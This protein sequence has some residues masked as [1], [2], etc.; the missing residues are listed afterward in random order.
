VR[1]GWP[2]PAPA[3]RKGII[4]RDIKPGNILLAEDGT[5]KITDFGLARMAART[6]DDTSDKTRTGAI[7]GTPSYMAPEQAAGKTHDVGPSVDLYA[8]GAILYECLTGRPP[9]AGPTMLDTLMMVI[10][11][12]PVPPRQ[13]NAAIPRD[14]ET[15]CLK[16]L[17]KEVRNRY[18]SAAE[19]AD[20]LDRY[21]ADEPILA[22]PPG[23]V[24][25]INRWVRTHQGLPLAAGLILLL[26][27]GAFALGWLPAVK[28]LDDRV[29]LLWAVPLL[30]VI[31]PLSLLSPGRWSRVAVVPFL[32]AALF[33]SAIAARM[34]LAGGLVGVVLLSSPLALVVLLV[35]FYRSRGVRALA[36]LV[37]AGCL[38]SAVLLWPVHSQGFFFRFAFGTAR[39]EPLGKGAASGRG[40]IPL[41]PWP[42]H[43]QQV[44]VSAASVWNRDTALINQAV[45][46]RRFLASLTLWLAVVSHAIVLGALVHLVSW[47]LRRGIGGVLVGA[48]IGMVIGLGLADLFGVDMVSYLSRTGLRRWSQLDIALYLELALAYAGAIVGGLLTPAQRPAGDQVVPS[49]N[50]ARRS[51]TSTRAADAGGAAAN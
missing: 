12:E 37:L 46:Q 32:L 36:T 23:P 10:D 25:R 49:R 4:H 50:S 20:D 26:G 30:L 17:E 3:H 27:V 43:T 44:V 21:L 5:P 38:A 39:S 48:A 22:R 42:I 6:A 8:L 34:G 16:C 9:F 41:P 18:G 40:G 33:G 11:H 47:A 1:R 24:A 29:P 13:H 51:S 35:G 2:G 31:L 28:V 45:Q 7:L 15:I 19:L 14:L